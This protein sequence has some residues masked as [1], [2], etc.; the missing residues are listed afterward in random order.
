MDASRRTE[1]ICGGRFFRIIS[2]AD[3]S[4]I[5]QERESRAANGNEESGGGAGSTKKGAWKVERKRCRIAPKELC[6]AG[7]RSEAGV[8]SGRGCPFVSLKSQGSSGTIRG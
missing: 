7:D 3:Y 2:E 8:C 1:A 4:G 5:G 6:R